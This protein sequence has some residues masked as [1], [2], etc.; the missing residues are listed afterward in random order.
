MFLHEDFLHLLFNMMVLFFGGQ[1]L[2]AFLG[3][4]KLVSTYI[5]SGL[6]GAIFFIAA[7]NAFPVF[8]S[9]VSLA[10]AL[11]ASASVLGILVAAATHAPDYRVQ[12]FL[13]G[14][15]KLKHIALILIALDVISIQ[16]ENPGGHIA[17]LGGAFWGFLTIQLMKFFP[18]RKG[19]SEFSLFQVFRRLFKKQKPSFRVHQGQRGRP[20][21]DEEYNA[22]K[23]KKQQ[24]IDK[25]LDKISKK[26]Y[27]SLS[28]EEKDLLFK[29]GTTKSQH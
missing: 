29:S 24:E 10:L 21:K 14:S 6:W 13:L 17:H 2:A 27:D 18:G 23:A 16:K 25:I 11:G 8:E 4:K 26:G 20:L 15:L 5:F 7:F 3:S 19:N 9:S 22:M 12:L 28:R 1:L